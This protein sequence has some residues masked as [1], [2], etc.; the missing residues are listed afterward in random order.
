M[1][2]VDTSLH[3]KVAI[4]TGGSKGIGRSIALAFAEN[5][6]DVA[7]AARGAEALEKTREEIASRGGRALALSADMADDADLERLVAETVAT[8][9]GVDILVNNA[10]VGSFSTLDET[11]ANGFLNTMRI[12]AWAPLFLSRLCHKSMVERGGGV[13]INIA[14]AVGVRADVGKTAYP[15]YG[16]SK[17]ALVNLTQLLAKEWAPDGVRVVCVAPGLLR[18]EMTLEIM[19]SLDATN[20]G[21]TP[22]GRVGDP[23]EVAGIVLVLASKAGAYMTGATYPVDGGTLYAG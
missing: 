22:L 11:D 3:G 9:G 21:F 4:V 19:K 17:A 10:G 16:P 6:A 14:S 23:Q 12:N 5:G 8:L 1:P 13:I 20:D 15:S 18:S 7:I 2:I